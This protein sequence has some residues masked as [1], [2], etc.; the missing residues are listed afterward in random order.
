MHR[1]GYKEKAKF[2]ATVTNNLQIS[3][4][5]IK[6]RKIKVKAGNR[7]SYY[8]SFKVYYDE[9]DKNLSDLDVPF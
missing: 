4:S 1:Q 8:Y 6:R 5:S 3:L 7:D 2:V 9:N